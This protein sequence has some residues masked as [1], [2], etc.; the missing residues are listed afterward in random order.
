VLNNVAA[1]YGDVALAAVSV[2]NKS[3]RLVGSGVMGF[4]Q[5]FQPIAGYSWGAKRYSR[6]L[7][8]FGYTTLIAFTI[9]SVFG[10]VMFLNAA[11]LIAIFSDDPAVVS[12]GMVLIR[13]QSVVLAP[14]TWVMVST[15]LFQ[16]LGKPVRAA[17][18]GL[19]RQILSLIPSVIILN[20]LFGLTG[21]TYAQATADVVAFIF[22]LIFIL[23][24]IGELRKMAAEQK[25]TERRAEEVSHAVG[26]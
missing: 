5:G 20:Y 3:L 21:L 26:D 7:K 24:M 10:V 11:N 9:G 19:S 8:A 17:L 22:A 16:A 15:G 4:G 25:E 1:G 2:S 6:V 14:H 13:S 12:L 18:T 23:P